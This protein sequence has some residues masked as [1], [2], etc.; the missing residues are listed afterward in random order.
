MCITGAHGHQLYSQPT[1]KVGGYGGSTAA[2]A[3]ATTTAARTAA[4]TTTGRPGSGAV[5]A[6]TAAPTRKIP[7]G[8]ETQA[9]VK[10]AANRPEKNQRNAT[11]KTR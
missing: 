8:A 11:G 1:Q 10:Q 4:A 3:T 5:G 2:T 7:K 6:E 9:Q